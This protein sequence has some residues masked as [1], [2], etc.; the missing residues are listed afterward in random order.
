MVKKV[1]IVI[2][3]LGAFWSLIVLAPACSNGGLISGPSVVK[4]IILNGP[5]DGS[6]HLCGRVTGLGQDASQSEED[7]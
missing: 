1:S 2:Y 7:S 4:R 6:R 3:L 5:L